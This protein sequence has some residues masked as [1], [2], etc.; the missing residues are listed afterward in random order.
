MAR[1]RSITDEQIVEAAHE[2]FLEQG[3]SATTAAIAR[4]A[5]VSE[6]T[7]FNRFQSKEEL[8]VAAIG[9]RNYGQ[10][11]SQLLAHVGQG[12]VH[13]NLERALM[14]LLQEATSLLPKLMVMFSRGHDPS[15]NPLLQRLDDPV[16]SDAETL[17]EYLQAE[18]QLGRV[19]PMDAAVTSLA[20]MGAVTHYIHRE[21]M[22]PA[23]GREVVDPARFVRGLLDVMWPGLEP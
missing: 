22:L 13:R 19:R 1:P 11:R 10:W 18:A 17:A 2:V 4:R 8:F 14:A 9:L 21:Q 7:L 20:L 23:L 3:F 5:G 16:R 12:E 6:G 15:H